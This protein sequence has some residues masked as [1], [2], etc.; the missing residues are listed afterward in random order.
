MN[1][2]Q[3]QFIAEARELI[4]QTTDDLIAAEG[5]G[6]SA[7]RVDRVFRAFHTLKGSAGIVELPAMVLT[8]HAAEDL[9]AAVQAGR[10]I[11]PGPF[12]DRTLA[13]LD[14][15]S[16]WVDEFEARGALP[17][18]AGEDARAMA[19]GLRGLLSQDVP[20]EAM[21]RER[22]AVAV[23][24]DLPGW[25]SRLI[26]SA[27]AQTLQR[28]AAHRAAR[29]A[30]SYEP[31]A[32]CFFTGDDPIALMRQ[33]PELLALNIEAREAWR[34]PAELDPFACNLRLQGL[35]AADHGALAR[36]FRLVPD[37]VHIIDVP[38]EALRE[39]VSADTVAA[40]ELIRAVLDEQRRVLGA[41]DGSKDDFIGRVGAAAR[42]AANALRYGRREELAQCVEAAGAEAALKGDP[43]AL[44]G[45]LDEALKSAPPEQTADDEDAAFARAKETGRAAARSLRVD[46]A[47]IDAL[48][49][50]AG[51]LV[52]LKN[53]FAHLTKQVEAETGR[54]ELAR[55]VRR[56][57]EAIERLAGEMHAAVLQLRMLPAAHVLRSF[58][59]LVRDMSQ[60][61]GKRVALVTRG[62]TTESDKTI[63]DRLFEPLL[64][65]VRNAVDHG[66]ENAQER[67]AAG[68]PELAT[69]T[70]TAGR[71]ADR[72]TVEV[73][74]DGRGIDPAAIRSIAAKRGLFAAGE[75]AALS[76]EQAVDL[77]F[78]AGFSTAAEVSDISGR[79]VGMD[80]VR[81]A[82]EQMGGRVSIAS[83]VG[84][85]TRVQLE[86]PVNI[87]MS[88]IMVVRGGGQLFGV[89]MDAVL[90]T[91]RLTPDRIRQIKSNEG[92]VL[93][94]RI[95]P[96]CALAEL[97][98]LPQ[99]P[100]PPAHAR[101]LLVVEVNGKLAA[102]EVDAVLDRID[103]VLK[104]MQGLLAGA[105][106][107]AGTTLLG[108]G[109]VLP[110]LDLKELLP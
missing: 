25:V 45:V 84:V 67:G 10:P 20:E 11:A 80:V 40:D 68:K 106:G 14:Q 52:V 18:A 7:E 15:A 32:D 74:D 35:S 21:E 2:L 48:V 62:E 90:E 66:V 17:T 53:S 108:D 56:E 54:H 83:S 77:I 43:A 102:L 93:R 41:A 39:K 28:P 37:Q 44:R 87:A 49:N 103:V 55:A 101:L 13:C 64:H 79:G 23:R 81:A 9:L 78:T 98:K 22:N 1:P 92:F 26:E 76:D 47:K 24:G 6:F 82:V 33:I 69:I 89:S 71:A 85:G 96:I 46:E 61:L 3:E 59:R 99:A 50:L 110:V 73:S 38:S 12:I 29:V 88:R 60:R 8:L 30:V 51:E 91:V 27:R 65:L 72:F 95:V 5:E 75:L 107:Y 57:H 100:K 34:A 70:I 94:D 105:R 63:L 36:L 31:R 109:A 104:P 86:L 16:R 97:M 19:E 58:P 4:H 42:A